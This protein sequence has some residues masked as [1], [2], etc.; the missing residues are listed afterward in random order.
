MTGVYYLPCPAARL[1]VVEE[2]ILDLDTKTFSVVVRQ[3]CPETELP[4]LVTFG[5][6]AG[7]EC[8]GQKNA[9]EIDFS[10]E[11]LASFYVNAVDISLR[12]GETICFIVSLGGVPG[13]WQYKVRVHTF[14]TE[15][16]LL[17]FSM[18][19]V[20]YPPLV[21]AAATLLVSQQD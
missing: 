17:Q 16:L 3:K 4:V 21:K 14:A 19:Q 12:P 15:T 2:Q 6:L 7:G 20:V 5:S 9:T 8:E 1:L 10:P 11:G 13:E 18:G